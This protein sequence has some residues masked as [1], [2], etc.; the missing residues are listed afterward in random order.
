MLSILPPLCFSFMSFVS[1]F[2]ES[3][4]MYSYAPVEECARGTLIVVGGKFDDEES[5][6]HALTACRRRA[7]LH[8]MEMQTPC[9]ERS[10]LLRHVA[11]C[12]AHY[13]SPAR[14]KVLGSL[15]FPKHVFGSSE[16]DNLVSH[17]NAQPL[18]VA[19]GARLQMYPD[20]GHVPDLGK[21]RTDYLNTLTDFITESHV[22]SLAEG[23]E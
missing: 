3:K 12:A 9:V 17:T 18:A 11:A 14:L 22:R 6:S 7:K 10:G 13:L 4:R 1:K 8:G 23:I 2:R 21:F 20:C 16:C 5:W 19:I 15:P